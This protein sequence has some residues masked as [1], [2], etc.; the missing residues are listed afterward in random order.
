MLLR[1]EIH[2]I[3]IVFDRLRTKPLSG[4]AEERDKSGAASLRRQ[5]GFGAAPSPAAPSG[6]FGRR[7]API[8]PASTDGTPPR[9]AANDRTPDNSG[10]EVELGQSFGVHGAGAHAA[11]HEANP[12]RAIPVVIDDVSKGLLIWLTDELRS[13]K[14]IQPETVL[15]ALG[16]LAGYA[17]QQAIREAVVKPGKLTIDQAFVVIETRSGDVFFFGDLLNAV[18]VSKDGG[19]VGSRDKGHASIWKIVSDGGYEAGALNLPDVTDMIKH[20]AA[21]VGKEEFGVPRIPDAHLPELMPRDAVRRFWPAVRRR[22]AGSEP[23]SWPL[24]LALAAHKL[25]VEL[26][27]EL[28]PDI[29]VQIVMEA[30]VPM[31]KIDPMTLPKE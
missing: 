18:I 28:R 3:F 21:T 8:I 30:A 15:C 14:S 9:A 27:H 22:L 11:P 10:A 12:G 24:H 26:K 25:I 5:T 23:M 19:Q 20:C 17:A 1:R 31:S 6:G 4:Q 13:G 7:Q 2:W 29:A 16:A